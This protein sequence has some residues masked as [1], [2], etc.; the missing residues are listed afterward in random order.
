MMLHETPPWLTAGG[1]W[2][3]KTFGTPQAAPLLGKVAGD[4]KSESVHLR[5]KSLVVAKW[6][7]GNQ[8]IK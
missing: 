2:R 6:K 4:S 5:G 8:K 3:S 7:N 1:S